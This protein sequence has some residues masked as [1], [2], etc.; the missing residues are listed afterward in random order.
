MHTLCTRFSLVLVAICVASI[1]AAQMGGRVLPSGGQIAYVNYAQGRG[2]LYSFDLAR[3]VTSIIPG[4]MFTF[5]SGPTWANDGERFAYVFE[6]DVYIN[7]V[8]TGENVNVTRSTA[9]D[10]SP[11]WSP[12]G[13]ALSFVSD[14]Y[15]TNR[16]LYLFDLFGRQVEHLGYHNSDE[17][18]P[19]WSPDGRT[20]A[21]ITN[22]NFNYEIYT[23]DIETR[24]ERRLTE[25]RVLDYHPTWSPDGTMI[26]FTSNRDGNLEVYVMAADGGNPRNITNHRSADQRPSWSPD[27]QQLV[28]VSERDGRPEIYMIQ[29]D[30][31]NV[32]R[33]SFNTVSDSFPAWLP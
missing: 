27:G 23:L 32:R 33:V 15:F 24:R 21:Y 30:G 12:D 20:I 31:T 16:D 9:V 17:D 26:A 28:F 11:S 22:R 29:I 5:R 10:V 8:A 3:H 19:V 13:L 25:N 18:Q 1:L 2:T 7:N 14:R 6:N 4:P